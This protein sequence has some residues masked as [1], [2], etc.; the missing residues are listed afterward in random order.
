MAM[1]DQ[2]KRPSRTTLVL[3]LLASFTILTLDARGGA[4]SPIDPVRSVAGDLF[5]PVEE[6]T[7]TVVRP[8]PG[9]PGVLHHHRQPAPPGCNGFE[10]ENASLRG[11][12]ATGVVDRN[13]AAELDGLMRSSASTG[14]ALVRRSHRARP[15]PVVLAD[16]D[17]RRRHRLR[18]PPRHDRAQQRRTRRPGDPRRPRHR[19]GAARGRPGVR[20]GRPARIEHGGRLP[21]RPRRGRRPGRAR[22]RPRGQRGDPGARRRARHVGL[23]EQRAVRLGHPRRHRHLGVQQPPR[24]VEAGGDRPVRGLL[25]ARPRRRRRR[26]RHRE[27]PHRDQGRR[28]GIEN[29]E[30]SDG[31]RP[32]P[33]PHPRGHPGRRPPGGPVPVPVL[34]RRGATSRCS[35]WSRPRSSAVPSSPR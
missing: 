16:R 7:A 4:D 5:G 20:G 30:P 28:R 3:L 6:A 22:P 31:R 13:R 29:Q 18:H 17:H 35:S 12:V 9:G 25:V 26:A 21:A 19:D 33:R 34:R 1:R 24:A 15:R 32:R 11:Q 10:A 2:H 14:Y 8:V 27:R 23:G